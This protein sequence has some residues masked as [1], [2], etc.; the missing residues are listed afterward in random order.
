M[1]QSKAELYALM[2]MY[3]RAIDELQYAFNFAEGHLTKQR[4]RARIEQFRSNQE[5]MQKI[6]KSI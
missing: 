2:A 1:H 6:A 4:I 5:R 3:P